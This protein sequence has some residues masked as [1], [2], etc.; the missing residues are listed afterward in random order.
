MRH[1]LKEHARANQCDSLTDSL[2]CRWSSDTSD[3]ELHSTQGSEPAD[4]VTHRFPPKKTSS[5]MVCFVLT[6]WSPPEIL[7]AE[8]KR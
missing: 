8:L 1:S 7:S 4:W 3:G 6:A 2:P 5:G